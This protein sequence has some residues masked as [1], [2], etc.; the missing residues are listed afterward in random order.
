MVGVA[1]AEGQ[2]AFALRVAFVSMRV[3]TVVGRAI[4]DPG[5]PGAA[6]LLCG[7]APAFR[8][9]GGSG[10]VSCGSVTT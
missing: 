1:G 3:R 7:Q 4:R 9:G 5:R 6:V 2:S 8:S 10:R